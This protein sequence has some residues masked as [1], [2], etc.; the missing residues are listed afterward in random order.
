MTEKRFKSA[1]EI[2]INLNEL[3]IDIRK[4]LVSI[5]ALKEYINSQMDYY[6]E[7]RSKTDGSNYTNAMGHLDMLIKLKDWLRSQGYE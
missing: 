6:E 4:E 1:D 5:S 3:D 2:T 7:L